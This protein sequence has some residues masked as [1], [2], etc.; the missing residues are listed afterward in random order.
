MSVRRR[1]CR[2]VLGV[3]VV[4]LGLTCLGVVITILEPGEEGS[5]AKGS[6]GGA[7]SATVYPTRKPTP[8]IVVTDDGDRIRVGGTAYI[9]GRDLEALPPLTLMR[10]N[11]WDQVPRRTA[12]CRV[13]HGDEVQVL[14]AWR[15]MEEDRY[16]FR[17]D[18]PSCEGWVPE[19]FLG[20]ELYNL[21]GDPI[22]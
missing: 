22:Y 4:L 1:G 11:A 7:T 17:V 19:P 18:G 9:D 15:S 21:V 10:I 6:E 2:I 16:Y 12:S 3:V 5:E 13:F 14:E 8:W 20:T